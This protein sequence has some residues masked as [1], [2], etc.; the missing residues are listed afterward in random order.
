MRIIRPNN[1]ASIDRIL[2]SLK[3]AEPTYAERGATLTGELPAGF[4]HVRAERDLGHGIAVFERAT[5]GLRTWR[6]HSMPGFRVFPAEAP[7]QRGVT[8]V[9]AMGTGLGSITAPC[10]VIEVSDSPSQF[11]FAYGTLPGHPEQGE[12]AFVATIGDDGAVRFEIT[13]FSRPGDSVTRLAGPLGRRIQAVA[14]TSYL[15]ALR[16]FVKEAAPP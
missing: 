1:P 3:A 6:A 13:A 11:G 10:R 9:V 14:T 2:H 15:R 7:V 8:V 16:R 12:E 4:H 5:E